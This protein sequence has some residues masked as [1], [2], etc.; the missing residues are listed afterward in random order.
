MTQHNMTKNVQA[1]IDNVPLDCSEKQDNGSTSIL[2]DLGDTPVTV[3]PQKGPKD[4]LLVNTS[5]S[6]PVTNAA[7]HQRKRNNKAMRK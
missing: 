5:I 7:P 6:V 4:E 1:S 2:I 3:T